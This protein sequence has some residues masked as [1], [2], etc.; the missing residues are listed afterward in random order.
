MYL[1]SLK[2]DGTIVKICQ[3]IETQTGSNNKNWLADRQ[4]A[5]TKADVNVYQY[6]QPLETETLAKI[7]NCQLKIND[8]PGNKIKVE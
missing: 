4:V 1:I 8:L 3:L 5:I 6:E 7:D 2:S